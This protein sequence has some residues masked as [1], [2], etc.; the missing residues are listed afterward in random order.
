MDC[1]MPEMDGYTATQLI[2]SPG[3]A[4][5]NHRIPVIAMTAH[6]MSGDCDKCLARAG[7]DDYISKPVQVGELS[8]ILEKWGAIVRG[9]ESG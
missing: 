8:V 3:S 1:Q 2:R 7:M 9:G 5:R 4:A 6:A